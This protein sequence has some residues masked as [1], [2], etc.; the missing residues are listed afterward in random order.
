MKGT[1][2]GTRKIA[3]GVVLEVQVPQ[4]KQSYLEPLKSGTN[5]QSQVEYRKSEKYKE[6]YE[7]WLKEC[8]AFEESISFGEVELA[9][10]DGKG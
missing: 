1:I 9:Y 6:R 2:I 8:R 4:P 5:V 7:A 3:G 10:V